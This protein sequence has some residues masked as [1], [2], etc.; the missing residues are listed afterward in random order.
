MELARRG[1]AAMTDSHHGADEVPE[2]HRDG[3]ELDVPSGSASASGRLRAVAARA[4]RTRDEAARRADELRGRSALVDAALDAAE[5]DRRR[6]GSLLAGGIAF[7]LFLWLLP[8]AL[9]VAAIAA[10]VRPS[11]GASPD[12]V[13]RSL[14]LGASVASTVEQTTRQSDRGATTLLAIGI[15]LMLYASMSLVRAL[16]VAHVLAWEEPFVRR[17]GLL[18]DGAI[19]S[20]GIIATIAL[21]S[22]FTYLRRQ[23]WALSLLMIPLSFAI[24]GAAWLGLSLLLPHGSADW[25]AL[26]PGAA[27]IA[28]GHAFLQV[29]TAYYFAP[30]L[31]TAPALYGSLG[32]AA[33]LLLWLFVIARLVVATAFLNASRW[34]RTSRRAT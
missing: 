24:V 5:L 20:G 9:F 25:R 29:A 26:L 11:G 1:S 7:R 19:V 21:E 22:T 3:I 28:V 31:T 23:D 30:K 17:P 4:A 8:A 16:R 34:R 12:R 33:T 10:L 6:A 15:V 2:E 14:G 18:R 32:S 27:V 13:A